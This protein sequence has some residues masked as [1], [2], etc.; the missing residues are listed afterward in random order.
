MSS[1]QVLSGTKFL[2]RQVADDVGRDKRSRDD[3]LPA[4]SA[5]RPRQQVCIHRASAPGSLP[6]GTS[7]RIAASVRPAAIM[8]WAFSHTGRDRERAILV[9]HDHYRGV[10]EIHN[11]SGEASGDICLAP[12]PG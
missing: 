9:H 8:A 4:A 6:S 1:S 12:P 10:G 7:A 11:N 5:D 2:G 3:P